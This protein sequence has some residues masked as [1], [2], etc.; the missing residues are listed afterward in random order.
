MNLGRILIPFSSR[1]YRLYFGGQLISLL[2]TWMTQTATVWL[3]YHLTGSPFWL[4][5][6]MLLGQLPAIV[7]SP[8]GGVWVDRVDRLKLLIGTQSLAMLQSLLLAFF[9]LTGHINV[10]LLTVLAMFQGLINA[11]DVPTR[12]ALNVQLA[13]KREHLPAIIAMNSSMIHLARLVG[14]AIAGLVIAA[15]GAG[16]C[17]L[18][19]GVSYVAVLA[20]IFAMRLSRHQPEPRG[21][22]VWHELREGAMYAWRFLPIRALLLFTAAMGVFGMSFSVLLP[23]YATG[24]F[25]GDARTLGWLMS[26][27]AAGSVLAALYLAGRRSVHGLGRAIIFGGVMAGCGLAAFAFSR[28]LWLSMGCLVVTGMG[29]ILVLASNN[30]LVQNLVDDGKRGRVMSIYSVAFL[31]GMPVGGLITGA[32]AQLKG[33]NTATCVNAASC[34]VL[35]LAFACL[36]PRLRKEAKSVLERAGLI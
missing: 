9:T 8:L 32:L 24:I 3:V 26:A 13:E 27:S 21:R 22:S 5:M 11:F 14:P 30:T 10:P 29:G 23:A 20:A 34:I 1:N 33:V 2:G 4:G 18:L 28:N 16:W 31:G 35:T 12:Q 17:F 6:V 19:D 36:M 15:F 25:D 7:L